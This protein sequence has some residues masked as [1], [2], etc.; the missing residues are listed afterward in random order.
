V[1]AKLP[2]PRLKK[3]VQLSKRKDALLA[4]L[5]DIDREMIRLE[6]ERHAL[7]KKRPKGRL[8]FSNESRK[9]RPNLR[10]RPSN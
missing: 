10:K 3:L 1:S 7:R 2:G 9:G 8:T 6:Q 4:E 5:Q